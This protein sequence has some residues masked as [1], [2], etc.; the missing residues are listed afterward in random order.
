MANDIRESD[1]KVFKAVHAVAQERFCERILS[2]V[3]RLAGDVST[4]SHERYLL[5]YELV[6][7]RNDDIATAFDDFRRST[8]LRQLG[9]MRS[10]G[11][12]TDEEFARFSPEV[13]AG[14]AVWADVSKPGRRK[15]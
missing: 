2:E 14:A 7:Q 6:Q 13:Q 4:G 8:A 1:W 3:T 5:V 9:I 10:R 12:V 15:R 11:L